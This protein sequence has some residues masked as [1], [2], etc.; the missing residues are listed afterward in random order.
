MNNQKI[1]VHHVLKVIDVAF[2]DIHK[3]T[4]D[5]LMKHITYQDT[6]LTEHLIDVNDI[7]DDPEAFD[8]ESQ[9]QHVQDEIQQLNDLC[10]EYEAGYIRFTTL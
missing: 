3:D 2:S 10:N 5:Y 1:K 9:P 6:R 8:L 7:V 4:Y